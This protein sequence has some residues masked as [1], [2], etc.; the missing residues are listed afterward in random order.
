MQIEI[1][2]AI[3]V[4]ITLFFTGVWALKLPTAAAFIAALVTAFIISVVVVPYLPIP[5]IYPNSKCEVEYQE[6]LIG[7][8]NYY[9][10]E[11]YEH[12]YTSRHFV[13]FK[14][15]PTG[16]ETEVRFEHMLYKYPVTEPVTYKYPTDV[17]K[18]HTEYSY[19]DIIKI[20]VMT[21]NVTESKLFKF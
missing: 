19:W 4:A 9:T 1:I 3:Y 7:S 5:D 14:Y 8:V 2:I 12:S 20:T 16:N 17:I 10:C 11:E 21:D 18:F 6:G 15:T 13:Y